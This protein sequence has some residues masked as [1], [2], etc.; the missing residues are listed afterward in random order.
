MNRLFSFI[1]H[2]GCDILTYRPWWAE[3]IVHGMTLR[4]M[5]FKGED[6]VS[7][8][9]R[10][11]SAVGCSHLFLLNQTH[12]DVVVDLRDPA[13]VLEDLRVYGSLLKH[14]EGDALLT[15]ENEELIHKRIADGVTTAD[16]VPVLLRGRGAWAAVHAGWRGLA[17]GIIGKAVEQLG[18]VHEAVI[19]PA[20]ASPRYE[21]GPEV[22]SAIGSSAVVEE[23]EGKL[24]LNTA[25]TASAQLRALDST[26]RV[27][28]SGICTLEDTRLHSFRRD[29]AAAGRC[30]SFIVC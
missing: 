28:S 13:P 16:C 30:V 2:N 20:A 24:S 4:D 22:V 26:I 3:G 29:G 6:V 7:D 11:C 14:R 21:V 12:G 27:E 10:L 23:T 17:N 25:A 19:F 1:T 8:S 18:D 9:S 5:C 15:A